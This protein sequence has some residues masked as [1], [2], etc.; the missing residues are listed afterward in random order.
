M[1]ELDARINGLVH[2]L[3]DTRRN[4]V[5]QKQMSSYGNDLLG[6]MLAA[7]S[8]GDDDAAL[9]FNLASVYNN[10]RLVYFAGQESVSQTL[11]FALMMLARFPEWQDLAREEILSVIGDDE[12]FNSNKLSRLKVVSTYNI[13]VTSRTQNE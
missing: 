11:N 8:D 7:A 4:A 9:E 10:A 1:T 13:L 3:V 2:K 6:R 12:D 5:K